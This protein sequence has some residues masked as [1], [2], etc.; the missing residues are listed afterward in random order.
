MRQKI[1]FGFTICYRIDLKSNK[2][3]KTRY[4]IDTYYLE[5]IVG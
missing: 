1:D 2:D 3:I 5:Q 4:L